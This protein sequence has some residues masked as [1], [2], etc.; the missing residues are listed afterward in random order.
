MA[1]NSNN[2][3]VAAVIR[4]FFEARNRVRIAAYD[5]TN[6]AARLN[7]L[8][9]EFGNSGAHPLNDLARRVHD[10]CSTHLVRPGPSHGFLAIPDMFAGSQQATVG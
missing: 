10:A 7:Q 4:N 9:E 5:L 1:T 8:D 2:D 3:A 6:I